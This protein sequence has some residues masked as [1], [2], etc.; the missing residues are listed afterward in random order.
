MPNKQVRPPGCVG[1]AAASLIA[2]TCLCLGHTPLAAADLAPCE[3]AVGTYLTMITDRE[4]VFS[5]RGLMTLAPGGVM[6]M[7]D[8]AQ[9]GVP[10][11][12]DPFSS[13]QGAWSCLGVEGPK[14]SIGAVGL[15]FVLPA[16]GRP[17]SM[18]RVDY[19][20]SLDTGSGDLSGS[21]TLRLTAGMDLEGTNPMEAPG[22]VVD[23]FQFDGSRV[24]VRH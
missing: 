9:G 8:S 5:S 7:S 6:F 17:P 3:D 10:G 1:L 2:A 16:D 13:S 12:W 4:G 21:A 22:K 18:G 11:V 23:A 24:T 20:A 15:N 19:R 14:L